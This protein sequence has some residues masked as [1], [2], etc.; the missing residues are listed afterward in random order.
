MPYLDLY[1]FDSKNMSLDMLFNVT[2]SKFYNKTNFAVIESKPILLKGNRQAF[3]LVYD[4]IIGGDEQLEKVQAYTIADGKV[5][6]ISFTSQASLFS[7]YLPTVNK[8][9]YSFEAKDKNTTAK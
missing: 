4:A 9:I 1:V 2:K 5:Y 8:M 6:T 3:E 7:D